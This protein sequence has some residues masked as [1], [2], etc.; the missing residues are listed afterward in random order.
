MAKELKDFTVRLALAGL[1][2]LPDDEINKGMLELKEELV[3]REHLKN[4]DVYW[5]ADMQQ[6]IVEVDVN[7]FEHEQASA[8]MVE[9]ILAPW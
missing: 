7:I 9:E 5:D 3:A 1:S 8:W 6:V 4:V 2:D